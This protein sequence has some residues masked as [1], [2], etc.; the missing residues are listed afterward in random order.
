[1]LNTK[2]I[3]HRIYKKVKAFVPERKK[4]CKLA[5][6][7]F[8]SGRRR[9]GLPRSGG[10]EEVPSG[11]SDKRKS[12]ANGYGEPIGKHIENLLT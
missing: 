4:K 8:D 3:I 11:L 7:G 5:E 12:K 9:I 6:I 10:R 1:M 2:N